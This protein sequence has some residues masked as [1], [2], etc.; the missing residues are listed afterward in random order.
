VA[1]KDNRLDDAV[2][3][4]GSAGGVGGSAGK[5]TLTGAIVQKKEPPLPTDLSMRPKAP[6]LDGGIPKDL[7]PVQHDDISEDVAA[8]RTALY[9]GQRE[10]TMQ[11]WVNL[12]PARQIRWSES[13]TVEQDLEKMK[14]VLG[15]YMLTVMEDVGLSFD[16]RPQ[17]L[18]AILKDKSAHN[19]WLAGLARHPILWLDFLRTLP[20]RETLTDDEAH[21]IAKFAINY[22]DLEVTKKLFAHVYVPL[23]DQSYDNDYVHVRPWKKEWIQRLYNVITT[24]PVQHVHTLKDF[25]IGYEWKD[26]GKTKFEP[27][28]NGWFTLGSRHVILNEGSAETGGGTNHNMTG[29]GK[30]GG[31]AINHFDVGALHETG[32]GVGDQMGGDAWTMTHPYVGWQIKMSAD[33]WSKGLWGSDGDMKHRLQE[34]LGEK[35]DVLDASEAR[36]YM[37]NKIGGTAYA[38]TTPGFHEEKKVQQFI[39]KHWGDQKLTKYWERVMKGEKPDDLY[40]FA[41]EA[42]V[43]EDDRVYVFCSR[44]GCNYSSYNAEARRNRVSG[45]SMASPYEWFAEQYAH[46]YRLTPH[47]QGLD[48]GTK[49][50]LDELNGE[51]FEDPDAPMKVELDAA[52]SGGNGKANDRQPFPW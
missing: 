49:K 52:P 34:K 24:L 21:R 5:R 45:Y 8:F 51:K 29:G 25:A 31:H 9:A 44:V 42:N 40:M 23:T 27:L 3:G 33:D 15:T 2:G 10:K 16:K 4:G 41:G 43:G 11:L 26:T 19:D 7:Q 18:R 36:K 17:L 13:E 35:A 39:R 46:Y 37:A 32:H 6:K 47:G 48:P 12:I 14:T 22:D 20:A 38:V 28:R 50:K 30:K 1:P